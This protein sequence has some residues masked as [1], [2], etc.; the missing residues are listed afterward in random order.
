LSVGQGLFARSIFN[1]GDAIVYYRGDLISVEAYQIRDRDGRG[2]YCVQITNDLVLDCYNNML[3][4]DCIAS[5]ANSN[6]NAF[7]ANNNGTEFVN[8]PPSNAV[9]VVDRR[10]KTAYLR[11]T[12]RI[13]PHEEI[14]VPYGKTYVYP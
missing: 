4:G 10:A 9:I 1:A 14:L 11:A 7:V 2:G 12:K 3:R 8:A 5:K 6:T 13:H